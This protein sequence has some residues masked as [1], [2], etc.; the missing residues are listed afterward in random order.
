MSTPFIDSEGSVIQA[1]ND[2]Q[3][4]YL[5][6]SGLAR[7]QPE[8]LAAKHQEEVH[9]EYRTWY[10][11][12]A[13][14]AL[15]T[16][17]IYSAAGGIA[18]ATGHGQGFNDYIEANDLN[19]SV[20]SALTYGAGAIAVGG[21]ALAAAPLLAAGGAAVAAGGAV[22]LATAA[23]PAVG[24]LAAAGATLGL[25]EELD[26]QTMSYLQSGHGRERT[27]WEVAKSAIFG[28]A[29]NVA[30]G[31]T[32]KF[33]KLPSGKMFKGLT[34]EALDTAIQ[35]SEQ[36]ALLNAK[37]I[38]L[39]QRLPRGQEIAQYAETKGVL[40]MEPKSARTFLK[41]EYADAGQMMNEALHGQSQVMPLGAAKQL[42]FE[43]NAALKDVSEST[44]KEVLKTLKGSKERVERKVYYDKYTDPNVAERLP[45]TEAMGKA[46]SIASVHSARM[47]LDKA[48][49]NLPPLKGKELS[50]YQATMKNV[51]DILTKTVEKGIENGPDAKHRLAL[52]KQA[53]LQ[54]HASTT[55]LRGI[56]SAEGDTAAKFFG[57]SA[58]YGTAA[59]IA[60]SFGIG[61][62]LGAAGAAAG[63]GALNTQ[64][65]R[66]VVKTFSLK[67]VRKGLQAK[68]SALATSVADGMFGVRHVTN[69]QTF[70]PSTAFTP[71]A[72]QVQKAAQ[73]PTEAVQEF[74]GK[75]E[76]QGLPA[77]IHAP[78]AAQF[79]QAMAVC[80]QYRPKN[81]FG[82][83]TVS[84]V[85]YT[86]TSAEKAAFLDCIDT[87]NDPAGALAEPTPQR[88][89]V[90][91][92]V[93]PDMLAQAREIV[94]KRASVSELG[95]RARQYAGAVTGMPA[96]PGE[97]PE[98]QSAV[99]TLRAQFK[100]KKAMRAQQG[101]GQARPSPGA[102]HGLD[103]S[104]LTTRT[105]RMS[106]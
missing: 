98:V 5:E 26:D 96:S 39:L 4:S 13:A 101:Q 29:A 67:A 77:Q 47:N 81:P 66:R 105:S 43:V 32:A 27:F 45:P 103:I 84:P 55:L 65:N 104:S 52:Y 92:K 82:G 36:S 64:A 58:A 74:V 50:Q 78:L 86:P 14:T 88:I 100:Q 2:E 31:G 34:T 22:G 80:E 11:Q 12:V 41:S 16:P 17:G 35:K 40:K 79:Q 7:A 106:R 75:L 48:A 89:D 20:K 68:D 99:A 10:N 8:Q 49:N 61:V 72:T 62:P 87:I 42:N 30:L 18:L 38:D 54:A 46:P 53:N 73:Q 93:Y 9:A 37:T 6:Q 19:P 91:S 71:L 97:L 70:T 90:L 63:L 23:A 57:R 60:S 83:Q 44:R 76:E 85:D 95:P 102:S 69:L 3:A 59:A 1:E 51:R 94:M 24:G 33:A 56:E 28:A 25:V 21:A 15:K